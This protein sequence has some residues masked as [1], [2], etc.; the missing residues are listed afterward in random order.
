MY[1]ALPLVLQDNLGKALALLQEL[2]AVGLPLLQLHKHKET[3]L[4]KKII[5]SPNGESKALLNHWGHGAT[6]I[7][8][9]ER[10]L[11]DPSPVGWSEGGGKTFFSTF[12]TPNYRQVFLANKI[13]DSFPSPDSF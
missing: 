9:K 2:W 10:S 1:L 8:S 5:T 6:P 7:D 13:T 11:R 12:E 4:I 3:L